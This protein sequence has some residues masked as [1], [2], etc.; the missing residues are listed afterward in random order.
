MGV[1]A[2]IPPGAYWY[3]ACL[4]EYF[5]ATKTLQRRWSVAIWRD[6]LIPESYSVGPGRWAEITE[7]QLSDGLGDNSKQRKRLQVRISQLLHRIFIY[8]S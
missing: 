7:T 6:S 1:L 8:L 2:R 3:P 4:I 5:P